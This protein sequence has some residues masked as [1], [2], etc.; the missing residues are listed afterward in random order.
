M[1]ADGGVEWFC[2]KDKGKDKL[3][4]ILFLLKPFDLPVTRDKNYED[5]HDKF[6]EGCSKEFLKDKIFSYYGSFI[7]YGFEELKDVLLFAD[8]EKW[9]YT[10]EE[11]IDD[12]ETTPYYEIHKMYHQS[13]IEAFI[14]KYAGVEISFDLARKYLEPIKNM[15]LQEWFD[16]LKSYIGAYGCAETWT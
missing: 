12:F 14:F 3:D 16:E 8:G 6:F 2:I 4:R 13:M 15:T 9:D 7:G 11:I 5:Y 1:G 10:F